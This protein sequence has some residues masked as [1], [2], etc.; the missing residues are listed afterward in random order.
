MSRRDL[1]RALSGVALLLFAASAAA[2]G[3]GRLGG[4]VTDPEGRGL[5]AVR[6][7]A[8]SPAQIGGEQTTA[9]DDSGRFLYPRL[10]PGLYTVGL[11]LEGHL[12]QTL[13]EIRVRLGRTTDLLVILPSAAFGEELLVT[14]RSYALDPTRVSTGESLSQELLQRTAIGFDRRASYLGMLSRAPGVADA[15][16]YQS[17]PAMRVHGSTPS[18]NTFLVDG[19]DTTNPYWGTART[20]LPFDAV[21]EIGLETAGFEATHGR[22]TGGVVNVVTRSGG[23]QLAASLDLRYRDEELE[24]EGRHYDPDRQPSSSRLLSATLGGRM[25]RDRAWFFAALEEGRVETTPTGSPATFSA[26]GKRGFLKLTAQPAPGWLGVVKGH[27]NPEEWENVYA[28][29]FVAAEAHGRWQ[30]D[31]TIAQGELSA[32]LA[33]ELLWELRAGSHRFDEVYGPMSGDSSIAGRLNLSTGIWTHNE[34]EQ[35]TR[36]IGRRQIGGTLSWLADGARDR[37]ELALGVE[38]HETSLAIESCYLGLVGGGW[39]RP[40]ADGFLFLDLQGSSGEAAP[41]LMYVR[42]TLPRSESDGEISSLFLQDTWRAA[43]RVTIKAGLRW[44][45][46]AYDNDAGARVAELEELQPRL[47]LAW[48]PVGNG[49]SLLRASWGRFAH[50]AFLRLPRLARA[51]PEELQTW[52]SC[53]ANGASDPALCQAVAGG[54]GLPWRSDPESRDPAGWLLAGIEGSDPTRVAAGL[55]APYAETLVAAWERELPRR[56]SLELSWVSKRTRDLIEDTCAG[57]YPTPTAGADCSAWVIANLR[58]ARRDY[59]AWTVR[60]ESRAFDRLYLLAGF[61]DARSE[62]ST[63][64]PRL[65]TG[66]FDRYPYHF[67]NRYGYLADHGRRLEVSGWLSLPRGFELAASGQWRSG[68]RWTPWDDT[69]VGMAGGSYAVEPRGSRQGPELSQLD[70]Q[71]TRRFQLG[72][73]DLSLIAAVLNLFDGEGATGWCQ[74]VD[75]CGSYGFAEALEW[76]QPRRFELGLRVEL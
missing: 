22:A 64:S 10:A 69:V 76:Q 17:E 26:E 41:F 18:E 56:T 13:R 14:D 67:E 61:T 25:V 74:D 54:L 15:G 31:E 37:H 11:E 65:A 44:E 62:G 60:L 72:Q 23:N 59:R 19:L 42:P 75:G 32:V 16:R 4:R 66:A 71:L 70:V 57:N 68:P 7:T 55:A 58:Q 3:T 33:G 2:T 46:A 73:V 50:P 27:V 29:P 12:P 9:T 34:G 51:V 20:V 45:R 49:K 40:Q 24:S 52:L 39:C 1:S 28:G 30:S 5:P 21:R 47:G 53:T 43:A 48:D 6:V 36:D 38:R 63:G 35:W 8:A